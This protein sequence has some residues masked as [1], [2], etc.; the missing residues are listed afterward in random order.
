MATAGVLMSKLERLASLL[1]CQRLA[2]ELEMSHDEQMISFLQ[3]SLES[4]N[5]GTKRLKHDNP[6]AIHYRAIKTASKF[7]SHA[8]YDQHIGHDA[9]IKGIMRS[10]SDYLHQAYIMHK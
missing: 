5:A 2:S 3:S 6:P 4:L 1:K 9:D 7:T 10:A 8:N